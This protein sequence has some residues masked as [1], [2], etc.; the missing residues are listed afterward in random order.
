MHE[1]NEGIDVGHVGLSFEVLLVEFFGTVGNPSVGTF[2]DKKGREHEAMLQHLVH[3]D[4]WS[5]AAT[6]RAYISTS[7]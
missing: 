5:W 2:W 6:G 4:M 1:L 7:R 3:H